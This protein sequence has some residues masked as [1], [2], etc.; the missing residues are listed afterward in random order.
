M[1]RSPILRRRRVRAA[2]FLLGAVA[3]AA[4]A[5]ARAQRASENAL[6][7]ADDAFGTTIGRETI[8]L[9]GPSD[10]RGF[11]AVD[12]GNAR[13]EELYFDPVTLPSSLLRATTTIRVGIAAQG[14]AFP[15]PTG[16]VDIRLRRPGE[17]DRL[18]LFAS[19]D[20][21]GFLVGEATADLRLG[22]RLGAAIGVG[23]YRES[24]VNGTTDQI[25]AGSATLDW[26]PSPRLSITP[27]FS[28]AAVRASIAPPVYVT[29]GDFLPPP[30]PRRRFAG[31]AWAANARDR[32]NFGVVA[33][34]NSGP[35]Q[36]RLGVFRSISNAPATFANLYLDV[37]PDGTAR[38][39]I[40]ADPPARSGSTSGELRLDRRFTDGPRTHLLTLTL[41]GR[42]RVRRF[43]GSDVIDLGP[44]AIGAPQPAPAP[45]F[46]FG[47]TD[48]DTIRQGTI[49]IA[50]D[51]RWRGVGELSVSAQQTSYTK[52]TVPGAGAPQTEQARPLL[53]SA[54]GSL[55]LTDRLSL[56]GS[57]AEGL[58]DS[59]AAPGSATNRN[60]PLPASD[61][62]QYDLGLRWRLGADL[63][64]VIGAYQLRRPYFQ[65]DADGLYARLGDTLTRGIE[66]SLSGAVTPRLNLLAGALIGESR[67]EGAAV[68]A[69]LVGPR[70]VGRP[71]GR[72]NLALDWRLPRLP[73]VTLNGA[74]NYMSSV[75]ATNSNAV[76]AGARTTIDLGA[77]Y[78]F[79]LG[80]APA[81]LRL[82]VTNLTDVA[83]FD[84]YGSGVYDIIPGRVA[85]LS[86]GVDL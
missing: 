50:Y 27:F 13:L 10:V 29:A 14:F 64:L 72:A 45:A 16:V 19:G 53:L 48:L 35:W 65:F 70:T 31:P 75:V 74:V 1:N 84:V 77:R 39:L 60:A 9:Y 25:A 79:K 61:T 17:R 73:G 47:A 22:E 7:A 63:R 26:R 52:R 32:Y 37:R 71:D 42:D 6:R 49:G 51:L 59:G 33:A 41:R 11:S 69:G 56:F 44:I 28:Y 76:R 86:L 67:V 34:W 85:Q 83:G 36:L 24:Y 55:R 30:I 15:A 46:A 81:Q 66:A 3:L 40:V 8:G 12:A 68:R 23:G 4:G 57:Y 38:Q 58:E 2:S 78:A 43:A 20:S 5:P 62:R 82:S 54:A 80:A 18:S 21:Y